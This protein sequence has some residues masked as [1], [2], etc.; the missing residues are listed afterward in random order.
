MLSG[1]S[2]S[3][4]STERDLHA[5]RVGDA[6]DDLL[7]LCVDLVALDQQVVEFDLAEDRAERGLG[8]LRGCL[9]VVLDRDDGFDRVDRR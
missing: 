9:E 8:D 6:V 7:Q 5:P 1:S 2:T 4:I 3:L